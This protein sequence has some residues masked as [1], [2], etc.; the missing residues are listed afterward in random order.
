[1]PNIRSTSLATTGSS[2]T[3]PAIGFAEVCTARFEA[4]AWTLGSTD[5]DILK[6][7]FDRYPASNDFPPRTQF[8]ISLDR[9]ATSQ[10][11]FARNPARGNPRQSQT[12]EIS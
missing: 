9:R 4:A 1:M 3:A 5:D 7:Q 8:A 10:I 2:S 11:R 6:F 12:E